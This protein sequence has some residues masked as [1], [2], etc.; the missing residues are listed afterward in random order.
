MA[1]T[2]SNSFRSGLRKEPK[3]SWREQ[4]AWNVTAIQHWNHAN[5]FF[6]SPFY[7]ILFFRFFF[8]FTM[9]QL[10]TCTGWWP[11][12]AAWL[13]R[14]KS[15]SRIVSRTSKRTKSGTATTGLCISHLQRIGF[16]RF[17]ITW[18]KAICFFKKLHN[19]LFRINFNFWVRECRQFDQDQQALAS[20]HQT[21]NHKK[22]YAACRN[23]LERG[24][25]RNSHKKSTGSVPQSHVSSTACR[26]WPII[27]ICTP[28]DPGDTPHSDTHPHWNFHHGDCTK[29]ISTCWTLQWHS[30]LVVKFLK[31]PAHLR[32]LPSCTGPTNALQKNR[33][34]HPWTFHQISFLESTH[35][36]SP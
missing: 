15:S 13:R 29:K 31:F 8:G 11:T 10:R 19:L 34:I 17:Q 25:S 2:D 21:A 20:K 3:S 12:S 36:V 16:Q 18:D 23:A 6:L 27:P 5:L 7:S 32:C 35:H 33:G 30:A 4:K 14:L 28:L 9:S 24:S 22:R 26:A 1:S